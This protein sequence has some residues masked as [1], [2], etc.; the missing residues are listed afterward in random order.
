MIKRHRLNGEIVKPL[1]PRY[2]YWIFWLPAF[3]TALLSG[4]GSSTKSTSTTTTTTPTYQ[5]NVASSP[6][7]AG[8]I[9]SSPAGINCPTTCSASF[10]QNTQVT[11]TATPASDYFF[12][13]WSGGCSGTSCAVTISGTTSVSAT[14]NA[15]YGITVSEAGAGTGTITSSPAGINCPTT[16]SAS[17]P[18]NTQVTLSESP[19][20]NNIFA[21]WSGACSGTGSCDVTLSASSSV[22]ATF[23]DTF[24]SLNHIIIFAQENRSLDHY[25]G[26]MRQ[27]WA[28]NNIPDQSFD[29]LPQFNPASGI[30]PLQGSVPNLPGC[31]P[32]NPA[33]PDWCT[34]DDPSVTVPSFHSQSV[35]TE[36]LSPFWDEAHEDWNDNFLYPS[37]ITPLINGAVVAGGNDARQYTYGTVNDL[38]GYRT[39]EYFQDSDLPYYYYMASTFAT[40][41]RWFAP[42]MSRTELNRMYLLAATSG[43]HAY[44]LSPQNSPNGPLPN[45]TI[46]QALQ[47]AGISWKI[48]VNP[49]NTQYTNSSGTVEYCDQEPA[50]QAQDLCLAEVSYINMFNYESQIQDTSTGLWQN[51]VPISQFTTDV[52]NG[53]LPQVALIEPASPAGLDE[54]PT[55]LDSSGGVNIQA[56][57]AYAEGL[58]N[59]LMYSKSWSSSALFF[60]YDEDGGFYDHVQPQPATPPDSL[61]YPVDLQPG[62]ACD[63]ADQST[64]VCSFAMTGYRVPFILV[65]PFAKKNYVSHTVYD[66]TA[67][68]KLIEE[69]FGVSALTARDASQADMSTDFFDFVN[70][71]WATPPVQSS[72]PQQPVPNNNCSLAAPTP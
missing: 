21:G 72:V 7:G 13:G 65:S 71:P 70:V 12:Q 29:G 10:A 61:T 30:A 15:G 9:T 37:A 46:F 34:P 1:Q 62:D 48:Y 27:Y 60:T 28:A 42:V 40:S 25:F 19:G 11:L 51:V 41:D 66:H 54:H 45:E 35:C 56:G 38:N 22:T 18:Q 50:G 36:E 47:N 49:T 20:T 58:I 43:G 14:F 55:D 26:Y 64:G 5:L 68:L 67:I 23:G 63:G 39:M 3:A 53:T 8:T 6:S 2:R 69:R 59:S 33:G 16:C 32:A 52:Q 44:P 24:Q 4:C 17:F 57:A 31:D